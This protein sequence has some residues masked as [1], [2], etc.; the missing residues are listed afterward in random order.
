MLRS[1]DLAEIPFM[2]GFFPK[3]K[4]PNCGVELGTTFRIPPVFVNYGQAVS[5]FLLFILQCAYK[6]T[7]RLMFGRSGLHHLFLKI[8][9][10]SI[11]M[12]QGKTSGALL[13][14]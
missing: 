2:H 14:D 10:A 11:I 8:Y 13:E 9:A 4:S 7:K 1:M 3:E 6:A 5:I 12:R